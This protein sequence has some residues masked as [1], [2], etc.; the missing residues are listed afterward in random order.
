MSDLIQPFQIRSDSVKRGVALGLRLS[1]KVPP[2]LD[3]TCVNIRDPSTICA[4]ALSIYA[5]LNVCFE[6]KTTRKAVAGVVSKWVARH[7][8]FSSLT[9]VERKAVQK[10][11]QRTITEYGELESRVESLYALAW[12]LGIVEMTPNGYVPDDFGGMFPN[13]KRGSTP[14]VFC[15]GANM[16]SWI[17][18]ISELD[19]YTCVHWKIRECKLKGSD[20]RLAVEPY[21]VEARRHAL[22]WVVFGVEWDE[23][24]LDT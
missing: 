5:V 15:R 7:G 12:V 6:P 17:A 19:F 24:S 3:A 13:L 8:L 1:E 9:D 20:L 22:E 10:P 23:I 14:D 16:R 11:S 2:L 18:V 21:V 4:R